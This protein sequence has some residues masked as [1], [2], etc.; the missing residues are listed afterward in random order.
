MIKTCVFHK[1]AVTDAV[2]DVIKKFS[3]HKLLENKRTSIYSND[4]MR[5]SIDQKVIRILIYDDKNTN[6]L[7]NIR[8]YFY[9][10][11]DIY[12]RI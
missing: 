6:L 3:L 1:P 11:E 8:G 9:E 7:E 10:Y 5:M 12:W 2:L 4:Q